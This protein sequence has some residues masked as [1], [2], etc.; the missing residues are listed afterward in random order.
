MSLKLYYASGACS[1]GRGWVIRTSSAA[2]MGTMNCL[3]HFGIRRGDRH[4]RLA[5]PH[6]D[7]A[8]AL[9]LAA[10]AMALYVTCNRSFS[11]G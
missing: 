10:S 8:Q 5:P 3:H 6:P 9:I 11:A 2:A 4:S 1:S 7:L